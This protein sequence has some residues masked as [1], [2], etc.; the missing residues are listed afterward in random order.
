MGSKFLALNGSVCCE[1][2]FLCPRCKELAAAAA[3]AAGR[4][5]ASR[6]AVAEPRATSAPV[7]RHLPSSL[8]FERDPWSTAM[9]TPPPAP[10]AP[11]RAATRQAVPDAWTAAIE[12]RR[13]ELGR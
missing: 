5:A 3:R 8:F 12:A 7:V 2:K 13:R 1:G 4:P 9:D 10:K 6:A 11:A